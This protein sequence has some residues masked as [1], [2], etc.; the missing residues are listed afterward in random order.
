MTEINTS[1]KFALHGE[2]GFSP[3]PADYDVAQSRVHIDP[4]PL[5]PAMSLVAQLVVGI[6]N[7][8]MAHSRWQITREIPDEPRPS[9]H[10]LPNLPLNGVNPRQSITMPAPPYLYFADLQPTG[11]STARVER[12]LFPVLAFATDDTTRCRLSIE[13]VL[14]PRDTKAPQATQKRIGSSTITTITSQISRAGD[15][16]LKDAVVASSG[17]LRDPSAYALSVVTRCL[18]VHADRQS[19]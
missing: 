13:D 7:Y 5:T 4:A 8:N 9:L 15:F 17:R 10:L 6:E 16:T 12:V 1:Q 3:D 14:R 19:A 11:A 2:L 18:F